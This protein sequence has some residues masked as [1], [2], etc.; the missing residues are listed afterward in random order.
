MFQKRSFVRALDTMGY[1]PYLDWCP[2]FMLYRCLMPCRRSSSPHQLLWRQ[3]YAVFRMQQSSQI[4]RIAGELGYGVAVEHFKNRD[5]PP[6]GCASETCRNPR[7][8]S[9]F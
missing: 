4:G 2:R 7:R 9:R 5:I 8:Q 3:G 1:D 6:G